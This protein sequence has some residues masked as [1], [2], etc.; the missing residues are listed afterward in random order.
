MKLPSKFV[1]KANQWSGGNF[2]CTNK[3]DFNSE[4][5]DRLNQYMNGTYGH[6]KAE[7]PYWHIKPMLLVEEYLEDQFSELVDYKVYCF[8]GEPKFILVCMETIFTIKYEQ[9]IF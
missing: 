2:I 1:V 5:K 6:D 4:V 3:D 7:W 8:N 9:A